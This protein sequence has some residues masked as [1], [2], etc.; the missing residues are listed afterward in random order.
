MKLHRY[1]KRMLLILVMMVPLFVFAQDNH[2]STKQQ[3]KADQKKEQRKLDAKKSELRSKKQHMKLQDKQ[4][5]KRMKK[6]KRKG[7]Q[8]VSR[9]PNFFNRLFGGFR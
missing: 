7:K 1:L 5:R 3:K 8:Y 4:T 6:N 9:R 2:K